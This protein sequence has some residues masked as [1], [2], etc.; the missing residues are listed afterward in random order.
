[1]GEAEGGEKMGGLILRSL[2][3]RGGQTARENDG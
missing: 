1:M 3:N 2:V